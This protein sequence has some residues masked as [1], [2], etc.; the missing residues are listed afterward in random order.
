MREVNASYARMGEIELRLEPLP[1]P[2]PAAVDTQPVDESDG[3]RRFLETLL[4]S[5]GGDA[6]PFV[7]ALKRLRAA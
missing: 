1:P 5:A 4:H 3:E 7:D 6:A 2:T